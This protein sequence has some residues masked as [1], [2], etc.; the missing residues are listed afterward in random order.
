MKNRFRNF[1]QSLMAFQVLIATFLY[2]P[3]SD[4]SRTFSCQRLLGTLEAD[5][6]AC[7][8][9]QQFMLSA[10]NRC[11]H[12][13]L[14]LRKQSVTALSRSAVRSEAE[15]RLIT[16]V[17]HASLYIAACGC[18]GFHRHGQVSHC[19]QLTQFLNSMKDLESI[20]NP[21]SPML[22]AQARI[23]FWS[24][25]QNKSIDESLCSVS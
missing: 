13:P 21:Q 10:S 16:R 6:K 14:P 1:S 7:I 23:C 11:Y 3:Y 18:K 9:P 20:N 8:V 19:I 2:K 5:I 22:I 15:R 4:K 17:A 12:K 24:M 25:F